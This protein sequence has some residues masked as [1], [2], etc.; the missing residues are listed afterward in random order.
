[1]AV[2]QASV[3]LCA[4]SFVFQIKKWPKGFIHLRIGGEMAELSSAEAHGR[5]PR[6]PTGDRGCA[7]IDNL[8]VAPI[9]ARPRHDE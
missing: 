3:F 2:M 1:M 6:H 7:C 9:D 8:G 4:R 5:S